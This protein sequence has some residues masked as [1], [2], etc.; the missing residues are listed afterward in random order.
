[1]QVKFDSITYCTK[2][3]EQLRDFYINALGCENLPELSEPPGF[4]MVQ[5][6]VCKLIFQQLSKDPFEHQRNGLLEIG[7]EVSD[8]KQARENILACGGSILNEEQQMAWGQAFTA[9]DPAGNPINIY[10]F[11]HH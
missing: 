11:S 2:E 6:G 9:S 7:M 1:M 4:C 5:A 8:I 10:K 3:P